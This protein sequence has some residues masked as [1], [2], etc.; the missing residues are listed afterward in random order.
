MHAVTILML[1]YGAASLLHFAHNALYIDEYPNLPAWLSSAIVWEAWFAEAALGIAGYALMRLGYSLTG[2][3][4]AGFWAALGFDGL[5][6]YARAPF[7]A[8][9]AMMNLTIWLEVLAAALLLTVLVARVAARANVTASPPDRTNC[10]PRELSTPN[11]R[12][13]QNQSP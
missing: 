10:H 8:H 6:H 2:M 7:A 12:T 11:L 5:A 4:V 3:A 9:T 13:D 1:A